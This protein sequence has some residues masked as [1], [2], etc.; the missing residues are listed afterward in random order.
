LKKKFTAHGRFFSLTRF[1][2]LVG[3]AGIAALLV[4]S[5]ANEYREADRHAQ[6]EAENLSRV[7]EEHT[8]AVVQKIDLLLRDVQRHVHPADM[9]LAREAGGPRARELHALLK[10]HLES[11]PEMSLLHLINA[12]GE[13]LHS[14]L[15]SLPRANLADRPYF[16]RQR[17]DA[18]A[19]LVISSPV[20]SRTTGNWTL[21]LSR[22]LNF[23]DGSFAG[24]VQASLDMGYFQ[25]LYRSLDLGTHGTVLL[26]DRELHLAARFPPSEKDMG[27][28]TLGHPAA[29]FLEKGLKHGV[30]HA[31]SPLDAVE[32]VYSFRQVGDL[33]LI[34][35]AGLAKDDYLAEWRRHVWQSGISVVILGLLAIGFG[36]RQR[37]AEEAIRE[38]EDKYK[39]LFES[40]NDGI[41][42]QD[43]TGFVDCNER[44]A[45]MY[46]LA[47]ADVIGHSPAEFCPE[48]QPD[49]RLSAEVAAEKTQAAL[50]GKPQFFEWQPR[51]ADK[52]PFDV[53]ISL[54]RVEFGGSVY[55]QAIVRDISKRKL[56]EARIHELNETLEQRVTE[57]TAKNREKDHLMMQQS[58]LAAMGEMIGNIAHQWR[59]PLSALSVLLQNI[60]LDYED[61]LLDRSEVEDYTKTGTHLIQ[62]M[63]ATIDDFR[64]FFKPNKDK[65]SFRP[66]DSVEEA[67]KLISHCF[68][69][70]NIEVAFE[71]CGDPCD[72]MG[73]P[74]EFSQ[75]VLNALTN[76]KEIIVEK[77]ILGKVHIRVEKGTDMATISIRDNGGGVPEGILPKIF[78]PYFTTKEKGT[79]IGLYMSK[80]IMDNMGGDI[81]IHNVED[82]AEVLLTLPLAKETAA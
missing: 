15:A 62:K 48:R 23:E 30:Y 79:G 22:R 66:S 35:L 9:R 20:V 29:P 74:N 34:V 41:F 57:E 71:K 53:E 67:L 73:Y 75:V 65:Q 4:L 25:Q 82:G 26:R 7:L 78:D 36:L 27:K 32:R 5:L 43:A 16:Q 54:S 69:N 28:S 58:R 55:L 59:Q 38:R 10:S 76:A 50:G 80:M 8:L 1:S 11:V 64:N 56:A 60:R 21:I 39:I 6:V 3:L 13:H 52:T 12:K 42:L 63:S 14:S 61:G 2:G 37:Q 24:T 77:K 33:P 72:V 31:K 70:N 46:G 40:A 49:G 68:N 81:T 19:G 44:G 45:S 51:R 18:A 47:K 17:D